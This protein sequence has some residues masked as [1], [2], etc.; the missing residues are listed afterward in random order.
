MSGRTIERLV[1]R[2]RPELILHEITNNYNDCNGKIV[3]VD[4]LIARNYINGVNA[5]NRYFLPVH[6]KESQPVLSPK[7]FLTFT[8]RE[9]LMAP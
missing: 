6:Y 9:L 7:P 3:C 1:M 4:V 8:M 5:L 2:A